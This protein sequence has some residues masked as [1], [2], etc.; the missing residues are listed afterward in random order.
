MTVPWVFVAGTHRAFGAMTRTGILGLPFQVGS[1]IRRKR[2][3]H[4]VGVLANGSIERTADPGDGLP[5]RSSD[6]FGRVSKA[7]GLPGGL[8]DIVGLAWRMPPHSPAATPWDVL[9]ASAGTGTSLRFLLRPVSSWSGVSLSSLMPL[10]YNDQNWWIIARLA[11]HISAGGVSLGSVEEQIAAGGVRFDIDQACGMEE[12]RPLA[13]LT[14]DQVIQDDTRG[15]AFDPT[16]HSAPGVTLFPG[17]LNN[18][19]RDA[20]DRSRRGRD[21]GPAGF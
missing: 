4:P 1:A 6:V 21:G 17:W 19:R 2:I 10:R 5:V 3:F 9:L 16:T 7:V 18:L 13:R 15:V 20:Y 14:L 12:F 11:T 8:P